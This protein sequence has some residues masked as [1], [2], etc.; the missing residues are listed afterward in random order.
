MAPPDDRQ[1]PVE[2]SLDDLAQVRGNVHL[3][4]AGLASGFEVESGVDG[5]AGLRYRLL[6]GIG[7]LHLVVGGNGGLG[8]EQTGADVARRI[9]GHGH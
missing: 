3:E 2:V 5:P 6:R 9:D 4:G 1:G 7:R 8:L